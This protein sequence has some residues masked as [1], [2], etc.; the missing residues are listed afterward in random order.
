MS[1]NKNSRKPQVNAKHEQMEIIFAEKSFDGQKRAVCYLG[2]GTVIYPGTRRFRPVAG[3]TYQCDVRMT[4]NGK[5]GL[6]KPA[7]PYTLTPKEWVPVSELRSV[8]VAVVTFRQNER[9][10]KKRLI[11]YCDGQVV[12][13][14]SGCEV[15][16]NKPVHCMLRERGT[17]SFAIPLPQEAQSSETGLVKMAE[18]F[19]EANLRD[20]AFV[21]LESAKKKTC[22][23]VARSEADVEVSSSY[24]N[25]YD[26]LGVTEQAG[27][28]EVKKAY[29]QK[30][31]LCHPDKVLQPFGGREKAPLTVRLNAESF[32]RTLTQAQERA[33]DIIKRRGE[34]NTPAP[35]AETKPVE[36]KPVPAPKAAEPVAVPPAPVAVEPAAPAPP[37]ETKPV[38]QPAPKADTADKKGE[39]LS[40]VE[41][42]NRKYAGAPKPGQGGGKKEKAKKASTDSDR[43]KTIAEQLAASLAKK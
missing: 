11:G 4:G 24:R 7:L 35:A 1:Q 5:V 19:Q 42:F 32:F 15:P 10:G 3:R 34:K 2:D 25:I 37:A 43:P 38:E 23:A 22:V 31:D 17:V 36:P 33:L 28:T 6:A 27:E 9:E 14:D 40:Q 8:L 13:P 30:A 20:F 12:F 16:V 18:V 21:V 26:I 29:R 41:K 39:P